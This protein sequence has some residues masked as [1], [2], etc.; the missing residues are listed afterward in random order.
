MM[1]KRRHCGRCHTCGSKLRKVLD[2]EEWC[3]TCQAYRRYKSH[4][5]GA[6]GSGEREC[7][8]WSPENAYRREDGSVDYE[9]LLEDLLCGS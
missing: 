9:G 6:A 2:G 4:G 8:D 1:T 3:D 5:W 7:P